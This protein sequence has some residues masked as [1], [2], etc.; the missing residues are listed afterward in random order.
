[1]TMFYSLMLSISTPELRFRS[2]TPT[3]ENTLAS[4]NQNDLSFICNPKEVDI[5][6]PCICYMD[7]IENDTDRFDA[8]LSNRDLTKVKNVGSFKCMM[9][10]TG[11]GRMGNV[12]NHYATLYGLAVMNKRPAFV[13]ANM[14]KKLKKYFKITLPILSSEL[15]SHINWN[16][17]LL[18]D[19][20]QDSYRSMK[21]QYIRLTTGV[22]SSFTFYDHVREQIRREFT[23]QD[24]LKS[25]A[26]KVLHGIRESRE[27][28]TFVGVHVRRGD[29]VNLMK[30]RYRGV[31]ADKGFFVQ[32]T[33]YFRDRYADAVFVVVS[34]DMRWCEDNISNDKGD[35]Y[36][37]GNN[38]EDEPMRDFAILTNCNHTIFTIGTFGHWAAY[39]AGG[40]VVYLANF[41]LPDSVYRKF[42]KTGNTFLSHW[43]PIQANLS[44]IVN[45]TTVSTTVTIKSN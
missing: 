45:L 27:K 21:G 31:M 23:L 16:S 40:E 30:T 38:N 42:F 26:Q 22:P 9:T 14:A 11:G 8:V 41:T 2:R 4:S 6:H 1:M 13:T 24:D 35:V 33:K 37:I 17:I 28:I 20:L 15:Y 18:S 44:S 7:A 36:F 43:I 25:F 12:I 5:T 19:W 10:F 32:A 34:N 29:Y 3:S 39:I